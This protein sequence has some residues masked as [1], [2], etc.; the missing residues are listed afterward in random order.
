MPRLT[1]PTG[2]RALT[3]A[4]RFY[5][6]TAL[7]IGTAVLTALLSLSS[8]RD[9]IFAE[10]RSETQ[11]IVQVVA[12]QVKSYVAMAKAGTLSEAEAKRLAVQTMQAARFD[13]TNYIFSYDY[14]GVAVAHAN[15]SYLG[16]NRIDVKDK[17]S[18]RFIVR[19]LIA[20]ARTGVGFLEYAT[21]KAEGTEPFP[22][23]TYV[24]DI[25]EWQFFVG[26]GIYVDDVDAILREQIMTVGWKIGVAALVLGSLAFLLARTVSGPL[27]VLTT[28]M[29]SL[30]NGD[31]DAPIA[32][33]DRRDEVG[34]MARSVQV[35]REALIAK[36]EADA[37]ALVE[38]DAKARRVEALDRL[39][40]GFEASVSTL[41]HSVSAAAAR[42]ETT[43]GSMS[44]TARR[45]SEQ[46][47]LVAAAAEET[48]TNVGVVAAAS[49]EMSASIAEIGAQIARSSGIAARAVEDARRTDETV[50]ALAGEA[51]RIGAVVALISAV[52]E[53]TNLLA[54]NATIEAARAGP[55]GR[56]FAVVASEVKE[57]A[58]QTAQGTQDIAR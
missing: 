10:K 40:R 43:A 19:D 3:I 1:F 54:L 42:M 44:R 38:A 45:S 37:A 57:L 47:I 29:T 24:Q 51:E 35:F 49:E 39:T 28:R 18:G 7:G 13:G 14:D 22:K 20:A 27:G 15:L 17:F 33:A 12:A 46:S 23:L 25:P 6:V 4:R 26:A 48:S 30:S 21:P 9:T 16:T 41:T 53:Q 5:L 36:R 2:L 58:A 56:G 52:A 11:H 32:G 50:Q 31:L 34:A 55:A 8:T